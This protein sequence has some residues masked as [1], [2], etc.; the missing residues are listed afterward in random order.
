[1]KNDNLHL[2]DYVE[3]HPPVISLRTRIGY[4]GTITLSTGKKKIFK[5]VVEKFDIKGNLLSRTEENIF[6]E[7]N[8]DEAP[9]EIFK[10]SDGIFIE[11]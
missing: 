5:R 6:K 11:E 9:D 10:D 2:G 4:C 3:Y 8:D 1:M 7:L